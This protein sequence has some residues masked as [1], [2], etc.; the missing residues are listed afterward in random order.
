MTK[1][2][3]MQPFFS[4]LQDIIRGSEPAPSRDPFSCRHCIDGEREDGG[5]CPW[6]APCDDVPEPTEAETARL[7]AIEESY[8]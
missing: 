3:H 7:K 5:S 4:A 8:R 1:P 2:L 6:C